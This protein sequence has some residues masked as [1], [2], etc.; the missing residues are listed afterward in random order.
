[1]SEDHKIESVNKFSKK[2]EP[3]ERYHVTSWSYTLEFTNSLSQ[4]DKAY[5][6][7][8]SINKKMYRVDTAGNQT[9][10]KTNYF[11]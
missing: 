10:I 2:G 5:N 11:A 7:C 6:K 4:A 3:L 9:L 1:M 8:T